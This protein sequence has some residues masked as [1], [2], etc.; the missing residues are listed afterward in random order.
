MIQVRDIFQV[1]F[2]RVK[3]AVEL[4]KEGLTLERKTGGGLMRSSRILTD[5]IGPAYYTL[6]L[7]STYDS[8]TDF[9]ESARSAMSNPEWKTWY[10]KVLPLTVNGHR[11]IFNVIEE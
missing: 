6:V 11:E 4:W 9:E 3:E 7:E 2:G 8:L 10:Q 5:L 1:Q